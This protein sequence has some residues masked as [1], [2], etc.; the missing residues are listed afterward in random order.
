MGRS[1]MSLHKLYSLS[2]KYRIVWY[3]VTVL[4][5]NSHN[6]FIA[7]ET[8]QPTVNILPVPVYRTDCG[9]QIRISYSLTHYQATNFRLFQTE[10]VCR[11]QFQI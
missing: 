10:R 7:Q 4:R 1:H 9:Q 3:R 2:L 8:I 6:K 11:S 5:T